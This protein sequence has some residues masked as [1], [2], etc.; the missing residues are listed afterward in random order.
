MKR[1]RSHPCWEY[2]R[3]FSFQ[4]LLKQIHC[5][6]WAKGQFSLLL[7]V[8]SIWHIWWISQLNSILELQPNTPFNTLLYNL[9]TTIQL[10]SQSEIPPPCFPVRRQQRTL[11]PVVASPSQ[12]CLTW[13]IFK[14]NGPKSQ[15][16]LSLGLIFSYKIKEIRKAYWL[17]AIQYLSF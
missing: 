1:K 15:L 12:P 7:S 2:S 3:K 6:T 5:I 9:K 11:L 10:S 4:H 13:W 8:F 16:S 17:A 14:R